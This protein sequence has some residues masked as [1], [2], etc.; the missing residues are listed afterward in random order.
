MER[1][2]ATILAAEVVG[3]SRLIEL[4]DSGT[5]DAFKAPRENPLI[6]MAFMPRNR[7]GPPPRSFAADAH[8]CIMVRVSTDPTEYKVV[9]R[10]SAPAAE[11]PSDCSDTEKGPANPT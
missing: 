9:A 10:A 1:G 5:L 7:I 2:L 11:L 8:D 4:D 3:I 6:P